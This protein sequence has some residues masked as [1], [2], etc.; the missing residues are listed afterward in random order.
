VLV[1]AVAES[2]LLSVA[3]ASASVLLAFAWLRFLGAW[4]IGGL[5]LNGVEASPGVD[6]PYR[7]APV[8]VLVASAVSF[9]LVMSGTVLSSW[10]AATAPPSEAMR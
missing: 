5:F 10:R 3:A 8:P 1:R 9:V 2:L 7:L 4:G 6:V